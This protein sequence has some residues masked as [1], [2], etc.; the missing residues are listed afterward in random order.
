M[1]YRAPGVHTGRT[2]THRK[3]VMSDPVYFPNGGIIDGSKSRDPNNSSDVRTLQAGLVMGKITASGKWAPSILGVVQSDYTSGGTE[4]TV[5]AAQATE[6]VRRNGASGTLKITHAPTAA[7][8][9]VPYATLTYSA[10][11]TATGILT[12]TNIGA[13]VESGALIMPEDGSQVPRAIIPDGYGVDVVD[14]NTG[15]EIDAEFPQPLCGGFLDTAGIVNYPA[16][17]NT[18]LIAW[19]KAALRATGA[20]YVF[21]DDF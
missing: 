8:T 21:S 3:V 10:V 20:W 13:N 2:A 18:T 9:V 17:A 12:I 1:Q 15:L 16:A 4:I 7:G 6:I 5:T 14:I 11:D 19:L